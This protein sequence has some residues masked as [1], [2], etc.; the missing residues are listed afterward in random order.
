MENY[1]P[2]LYCYKSAYCTAFGTVHLHPELIYTLDLNLNY[3]I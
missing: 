2:V 1:D 3:F